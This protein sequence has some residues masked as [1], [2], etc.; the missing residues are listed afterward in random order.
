MKKI[1]APASDLHGNSMSGKFS[2]KKF[3]NLFDNSGAWGLFIEVD[4][5]EAP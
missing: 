3:D 1:S 4:E 5:S 2:W